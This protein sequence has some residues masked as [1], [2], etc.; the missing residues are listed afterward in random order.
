MRC[1]NCGNENPKTLFDEGDTVYCSVCCHRTQVATGQDDLITCPY[2]GRLRD[3]KAINCMWCGHSIN[4]VT[5]PTKEEYTELDEEL[6]KFEDNLDS[7]NVRYWNLKNK[8]K[9]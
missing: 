8:G 9:K 3:R 6:Q 7:S 5:P 1:A 4:E 2:C